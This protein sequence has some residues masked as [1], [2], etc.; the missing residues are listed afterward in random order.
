MYTD[1]AV[2]YGVQYPDG[3]LD[4]SAA[5]AWGDLWDPRTQADFQRNYEIRLAAYGVAAG[6]VRFV[7][8]TVRTEYGDLE[9]ATPPETEGDDDGTE[10]APS[11]AGDNLPPGVGGGDDA[12]AE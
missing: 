10:E 9:E 6:R 12:G 7:Q 4:W 1:E 3:T 2:Q 5:E 11:P 8:R